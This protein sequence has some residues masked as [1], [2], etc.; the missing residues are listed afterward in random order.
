MTA[1]GFV[2]DTNGKRAR[3]EIKRESMCSHCHKEEGC[4]SCSEIMTVWADNGVGAVKGDLVEVSS[5][6]GRTLLFAF[7]V[8]LL[9]IIAAF[10]G[11]AIG[12]AVSDAISYVLFALGM[13]LVYALLAIGSVIYKK[14]RPE[15][16]GISIV[17]IL[18]GSLNDDGAVLSEKETV[19]NEK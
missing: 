18:S 1:S 3:V 6:T 10:S 2:V 5:P 15:K 16:T 7:L 11:Y 12:R 14:T 19:R 8:F 17:R 9:P 13:L 4:A